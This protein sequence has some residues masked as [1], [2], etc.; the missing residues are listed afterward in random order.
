MPAPIAMLRPRHGN[1]TACVA[2]G[3]KLLAGRP[4]LRFVGKRRRD[5]MPAGLECCGFVSRIRAREASRRNLCAT[6]TS[7]G[8]DM[9]AWVM[10]VCTYITY[11]R[12][13]AWEA[14]FFPLR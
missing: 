4:R 9:A 12:G 2:V 10:Y 14:H 7:G 5:V 8:L 13:V 11:F 6:F 1:G 3:A